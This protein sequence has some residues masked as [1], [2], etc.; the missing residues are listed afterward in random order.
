MSISETSLLQ[1]LC[2]SCYVI[3]NEGAPGTIGMNHEGIGA[4][5]VGSGLVAEIDAKIT[6]RLWI[7]L[8]VQFDA[9][10]SR[11]RLTRNLAENDPLKASSCGVAELRFP[12]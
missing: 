5:M 9:I 12:Y 6:G 10:V 3:I 2:R 4:K 1:L 7:R 11:I 8:Y